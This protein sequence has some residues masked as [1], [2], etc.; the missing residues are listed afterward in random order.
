MKTKILTIAFAFLFVTTGFGFD[1]NQPTKK[2]VTTNGNYKRIAVDD[3]IN[4]VLVP[5]AQLSAVTITGDA[6]RVNQISVK[7]RGDE[8]VIT[9]KYMVKPYS[10]TVYVPATEISYIN[11]NRGASVSGK[12]DLK[13]KD[14]TIFV[15]IGS[16]MELTI[17][18]NIN[19]EQA[20]DCDFIYDK[21]QINKV[22]YSNQ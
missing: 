3:N 13:F 2:E 22:I 11:L 10:I 15:N 21:K 17:T 12:G 20:N 6:A 9:S 8:L 4:L 14:L 1:T 7:T 19:I 18:G 16:R 5:E